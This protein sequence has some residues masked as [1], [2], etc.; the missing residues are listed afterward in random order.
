MRGQEQTRAVDTV[1]ELRVES[2]GR[3]QF[4]S[5]E[6]AALRC[7]RFDDECA[8]LNPAEERALAEEGL[9]AD[10]VDWPEY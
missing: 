9:A 7:A 10:L 4:S 3:T 6:E 8:K 1:D 2:G 5:E